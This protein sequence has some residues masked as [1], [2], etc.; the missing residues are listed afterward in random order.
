[1][2]EQSFENKIKIS[3]IVC[4]A[5][6]GER[7]NLKEN[8]IFAVMPNGKSVLENALFP[9]LT[10][11]RVDQII[12][13]ANENDF[14]KIEKISKSLSKNHKVVLGG[15]TRTQSVANAINQAD[16]ERLLI[17]D[18]A[19]PYLTENTVNECIDA[20]LKFGSAVLC[21]PCTDSVV[22]LSENGLIESSNRQNNLSAQTPQCFPK[23]KLLFALSQIKEGETFTD[24]AGV[25]S[26]YVEMPHPVINNQNNKKLTT[27]EDFLFNESLKVGTGFDLHLLTE[28]RRLILGGVEIAHEKGLLGHSDADVLT[29]AVMDALLSALS[30]RD[31]GYHFSDKSAEFK[32]ISSM[33]LL[34]RVLKMINERG[35]KV[36]NLSAVVMAEKPKLS[37]HVPKITSSLANALSIEE[38]D[39]GITCT[40]C[41][42][43]G[44]VGREEAI[45]VQAFCSLI[46]IK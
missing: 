39:V 28:G 18:G 25:Y 7:S 35:Y 46:P 31:I 27:P 20:L 38:K 8:K 19:R 1:M 22:C 41:E 5:G 2:N 23:D 43:V 33:I 11:G 32:D 30:L 10:C 42:K 24:E 36:N 17:H 34:S 21:A 37:P 14:D 26:K 29:H 13:T 40:T 12:I 4:A 15:K 6:K 9:F 45:A 3:A 44:L 16:G